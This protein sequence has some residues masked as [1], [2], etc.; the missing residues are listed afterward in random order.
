MIDLTEDFSFEE[1]EDYPAA[2]KEPE[3]KV[4]SGEVEE[5]SFFVKLSRYLKGRGVLDVL[6]D[7]NNGEFMDRVREYGYGEE[8]FRYKNIMNTYAVETV[9]EESDYDLGFEFYDFGKDVFAESG[10]KK[11]D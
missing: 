4:Y 11:A 9:K 3:K 5:Q 1:Q 6:E 10:S 7:I 8:E 2:L